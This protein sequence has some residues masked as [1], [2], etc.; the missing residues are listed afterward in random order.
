[1][2][3]GFFRYKISFIYMFSTRDIRQNIPFVMKYHH[4]GECFAESPEWRL[5]NIEFHLT[6]KNFSEL[7]VHCMCWPRASWQIRAI[8]LHLLSPVQRKYQ[9]S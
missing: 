5:R 8:A 2:Q 3:I 9:Y 6:S 1:M 4:F 7:N